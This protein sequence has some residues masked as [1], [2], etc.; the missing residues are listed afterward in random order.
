MLGWPWNSRSTGPNGRGRE[1]RTSW[2][3]WIHR[4]SRT[5]R[6]DSE[7][8][9][10]S[11]LSS[12]VSW[13]QGQ[14][15]TFSFICCRELQVIEV[16]LVQ[17]VYQDKRW[18]DLILNYCHHHPEHILFCAFNIWCLSKQGAQGERG[19]PGSAGAKGLDGDPGRSGEPG[20]TGA[21]VK[22]TF[23]WCSVVALK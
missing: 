18:V 6:R 1:A 13:T 3:R 16:S 2:W 11:S 14:N 23:T 21:R 15:I 19:L 10:T 20:L 7:S 5:S 9:F 8:T 22:Q 4:S 12:K 17:M